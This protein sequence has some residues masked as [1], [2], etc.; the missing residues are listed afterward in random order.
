MKL[1]VWL[2]AQGKTQATLAEELGMS[3]SYVAELCAGNKWPGRQTAERIRDVTRGM[4]SADDF[5]AAE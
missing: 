3:Q 2:K 1:A 4:V 5:M